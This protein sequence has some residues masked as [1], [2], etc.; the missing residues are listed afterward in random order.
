MKV[1]L[2][3][4]LAMILSVCLVFSGL[5]FFKGMETNAADKGDDTMNILFIGNSMTYYNTLCS[6]VEGLANHYGHKVKCTAATNGG[7]TLIRNAKADNVITAIQKGGYDKVIIQ[8]I[9][10]SFDAD[11]H[12][13][14]VQTITEMIKQY[15]PDAKIYSY[16]PWPTKDSILGENSKLPYFTYYYIKAAKKY[17]NGVA[18]AGEAFYDMYKTEGKDYYCTDGKHPMP[19][20]TFV[21]ATSVFYTIFPEEAQKTFS[22][23]DYTY[24]TN[25]IHKNIAYVGASNTEVYDNDELNKISQYSY[26][27]AHQVNEVIEANTTYTSVAGEYVDADAEVNPDE[28]EPITGSD[29]DRSIF[30][31]TENIAKGCSVVASSEKNDKAANVTD[32]KLGTR[33]ESEWNVDPQWLYVDLGSVKNINK[34]G[35]SWEGAYA[36]RYYV[37]IS[38]NATDW[39]TVAAVKATSAKTVQITLDKTYSARYVRMYGTRRGL[40]AYGYSMY[41]MGVWEAKEVPTTETTT[42]VDVTTEAPTTK[43]PTTVVPTTEAPTTEAPTTEAPT[44]AEATTEAPTTE[45]PKTTEPTTEAP[46]TAKPTTET[47]ITE[48]TTTTKNIQNASTEIGTETTV[49]PTV[50]ITPAKVKVK[51]VARKAKGTKA[52]ISLKKVKGATGYVVKISTSK[53]FKKKTTITKNVKL[54]TF[55][56]KKLKKNKK[57]YIKVRAVRKTGKTKVYGLW[58]KPKR[59]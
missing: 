6:V 42:T 28:L 34:V 58:S 44:T 50:K 33:W 26:T 41:E 11:N 48:A 39:K 35:F 17:C 2:K 4:I 25:L 52:K 27:R 24:V 30:E 15:S 40:D 45:A 20:G 7:Y 13:E 12:M 54:T 8:D 46:T 51:K 18:P 19:L 57:Y 22:G 21:S 43:A 10:G 32:G 47:P 23:D 29:V 3:K 36:K 16:E 14:G 1:K 9:V 55:T 56:L 53:K 5:T 31:A 38:N 37:Q 49:G 59:I